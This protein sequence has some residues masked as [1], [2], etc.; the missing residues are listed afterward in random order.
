MAITAGMVKE[1]REKT[2]LGV[3]DCKEAL[4]ET[5]GDMD[6]AFDLL[7]K[8]GL[9][10]AEKRASRATKDGRIGA[11]IHPPG[12]VGV[13]LELNCETDFV[14]KSEDFQTLLKDLCMQVAAARPQWVTRDQIPQATLDHERGIY[15][16][17]VAD[18]PAQAQAKI[19][20]SKLDSFCKDNT[21]ME[22][23][24]IR[25]PK[26]SVEQVVK[27]LNAKVGENISVKRFVRFALGE[28]A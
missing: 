23:P 16:A 8:K 11:Y 25:D 14:A 20:E 22:Q 10:A 21:L 5:N 27:D 2:G 26:R 18:K 1:L 15:Q 4:A 13:L 9:A 19:I 24:F 17:Q 28:E 7:R 3:M 6:K 12:R